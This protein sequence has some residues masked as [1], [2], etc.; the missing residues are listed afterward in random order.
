MLQ[1]SLPNN[2]TP[3]GSQG[4]GFRVCTNPPRFALN[5]GCMGIIKAMKGERWGLGCVVGESMTFTSI[6][7]ISY[8]IRSMSPTTNVS[9]V[10][11][12]H[13]PYCMLR[14]ARNIFLCM[15]L[16]EDS[17]RTNQSPQARMYW[18]L[19]TFEVS[20]YLEFLQFYVG[21]R[22]RRFAPSLF[23]SFQKSAPCLKP[24]WNPTKKQKYTHIYVSR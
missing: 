9:D 14:G 2:F 8:S 19:R 13:P 22:V 17:Y 3:L 12:L 6:P 5:Q 1:V 23:K 4:L 7:A 10:L 11:S 15:R 24:K 16:C 18:Q 20:R 21:L